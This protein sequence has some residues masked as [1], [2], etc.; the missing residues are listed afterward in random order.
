M[1]KIISVLFL[2]AAFAL[3][4]S[5]NAFAG[6]VPTIDGNLTPGEWDNLNFNGNPSYPYYLSINDPDEVDNQINTMDI[7]HVVLLQELKSTDA[8]TPIADGLYLMIQVYDPAGPS[9]GYPDPVTY[10]GIVGNGYPV[11]KM[12]GDFLGDGLAD[13][14]NIFVKTYNKFPE[15][16]L[17]ANDVTEVCTG[18]ANFCNGPG[19]TWVNLSL[20]GGSEARG[21]V[22]EYYFPSATFGTPPNTPFPYR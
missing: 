10:P 9:L 6:V 15:T 8:G 21:S 16:N 7:S 14:F 4:G 17:P 18:S 5:V 12:A 2:V 1:K 13:N 19:A 22:L 3:C 11:V 20:A